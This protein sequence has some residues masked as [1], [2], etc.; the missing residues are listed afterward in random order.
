M[1]AIPMRTYVVDIS[2]YKIIMVM[3]ADTSSNSVGKA[4]AIF[5]FESLS[6]VRM[7]A[8]S[9]YS[10]KYD[11]I[12]YFDSDSMYSEMAGPQHMR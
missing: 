6:F 4:A 2:C 10:R 1:H 8:A 11:V 12:Y 7:T 3:Q 9:I 5:L